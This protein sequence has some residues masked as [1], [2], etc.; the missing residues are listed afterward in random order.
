MCLLYIY[1]F[2]D[3]LKIRTIKE[4]YETTSMH[5]Q[6]NTDLLINLISSLSNDD[7]KIKLVDEVIKDEMYY[8]SIKTRVLEK[9]K[10]PKYDKL[11]IDFIKEHITK[12]LFTY[13]IDSVNDINLI[14]EIFIDNN[15]DIYRRA[16][17]LSKLKDVKYFVEMYSDDNF[18]QEDCKTSTFCIKKT[19]GKFLNECFRQTSDDTDK[20]NE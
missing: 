11:K 7:L 12:Q 3:D 17:I 13:L 10:D 18:N 8:V 9:I 2:I 20:D 1:F 5:L 14:N 19:T 6:S 16:D 15:I 4:V